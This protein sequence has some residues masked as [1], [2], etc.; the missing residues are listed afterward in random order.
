MKL[1]AVIWDVQHGSAAYIQTPSGRHIAIDLGIGSFGEKNQTFSPIAHLKSKYGV[2][3][4]DTLI[5][6]HP[7]RDHLD[8]VFELH[9]ALPA[10]L[11]RPV[12][13]SETDVREANRD[14]DSAVLDKYF[15]LCTYYTDPAANS[16]LLAVNNGG[17]VIQAFHPTGS[18]KTNLNNHSIVTVVSYSGVKLIIPGDNENESWL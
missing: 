2:E 17:A 18:A 1:K 12:H 14:T 9:R 3:R 6:T 10:V 4:L 5:I 16:A 13:L 11:M 15:E 7:H 8:D